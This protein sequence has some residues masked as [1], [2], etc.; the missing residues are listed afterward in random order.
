MT[1]YIHLVPRPLHEAVA[2]QNIIQHRL[3]EIK[4]CAMNIFFDPLK[5]YLDEH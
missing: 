1:S 4:C 5:E 2:T 3:T